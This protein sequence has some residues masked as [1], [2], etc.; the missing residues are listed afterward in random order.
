[1]KIKF[2]LA[3]FSLLVFNACS[4]ETI[5]PESKVISFPE[6][7]VESGSDIDSSYISFRGIK[8]NSDTLEIQG[9]SWGIIE[10]GLILEKEDFPN[11]KFYKFT[12]ICGTVSSYTW[13]KVTLTRYITSA[14]D[15]NL[16]SLSFTNFKDTLIVNKLINH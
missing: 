9:T 16:Q 1:M 7:F 13:E 14:E 15:D 11:S 12:G 2:Y 8:R 4:D 6:F 10:Y 3:F 5:L